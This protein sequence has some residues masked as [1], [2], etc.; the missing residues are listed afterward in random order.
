M[1]KILF[2]LIPSLLISLIVYF[3]IQH[4]NNLRSL[5]GALQV[6][7]SPQS[8]VY[9]NNDYIG[10]TPISKTENNDMIQ[11]GN[12]T[13][14]LV[15]LDSSYAEYQEKITISANIMTVVDRKFR[16]GALSEGY[17]ISLSPLTDKKQAQLE[18]ISFPAGSDVDLDEDSIGKTPV[19]FKKPTESDHM[20]RISKDGYMEKTVRIR[21]PLG[22][23][24]TVVAY[25]S[26]GSELDD[27]GSSVPAATSIPGITGT[28]AP[29]GSSGSVNTSPTPAQTAGTKVLI[30]DTPTGFLR[31]RE[32]NSLNAAQITTV[33]PGETYTLISEQPG[34]YEIRL[35]DV[36]TGWISS[37]YARKQ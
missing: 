12:Y 15:P 17:V 7:S 25:L 21:T 2:V 13:I 3:A 4:Y 1:K 30:L 19:L 37:Q 31:V 29:T 14:R 9:L 6:T 36:K 8:K 10:R 32:S 33:N 22:Y 27:S 24:L 16:K 18:V 5:K 20:L 23:R 28:P 35:N 26:T 11:A 34:W